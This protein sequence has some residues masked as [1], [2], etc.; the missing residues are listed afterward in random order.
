MIVEHS[1]GVWFTHKCWLGVLL[2]G[3]IMKFQ[4]GPSLLPHVQ[5]YS[6][7]C[8]QGGPPDRLGGC[9]GSWT[10]GVL[11]EEKGDERNQDSSVWP[12][13][14]KLGLWVVSRW[15][16]SRSTSS[17]HLILVHYYFDF[18][19]FNPTHFYLFK[20]SLTL[21]S[22]FYLISVWTDEGF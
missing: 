9:R 8:T 15:D 2:L 17:M 10:A 16:M 6:S 7:L 19:F 3:L 12:S 13:V 20:H 21:V 14:Y 11:L 5:W 4:F 1:F 22:G 18:S